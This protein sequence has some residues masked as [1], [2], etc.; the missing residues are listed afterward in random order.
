MDL[1]NLKI[2]SLKT[3]VPKFVKTIINGKLISVDLDIAISC[4]DL[5][6]DV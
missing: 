5:G 2:D 4:G 3:D 1:N 6:L